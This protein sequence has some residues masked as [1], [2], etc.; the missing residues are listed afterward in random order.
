MKT[1]KMFIEFAKQ[2]KGK[3]SSDGSH[4]IIIDTYNSF[5]P[6]PRGYKV[7]YTDA[8]CATFI[9]A[10]SI[11]LGFT[12]IIPPE[13]SCEKMIEKFKAL[14][15]FIENEN[16]NVSV[17]DIV[18]YDWGDGANY[19]N[20]DNKSWCDHV[21]V[22]V[23][24]S[25]ETFTV[26]EGNYNGEVK[27]RTMK[28]NGKYLRG[29]AVPKYDK[30]ASQPVS[31]PSEKPSETVATSELKVGDV[32]TYK[33]TTHYTS[34][35]ATIAKN[36][37]GG[38]ATVTKIYPTGKHSIHLVRVYGKGATVYGWVD[39]K[40]IVK[41]QRMTKEEIQIYVYNFFYNKGL[42]HKSICAIMG[43]IT[44]ESAWNV[45]AIEQGNAIGFGLCQWSFERRTQLENYGVSLNHQCEFLYSELT[46]ENTNT[47]GA[48]YQWIANPADSVDNGEGFYCSN[49]DF[50]NGNG[51]IE[52]LTK[53]FCYCWERPA[54]ATNHLTETR[55]PSAITFSE[56]MGDDTGGSGDSDVDVLSP[57]KRKFKF[58]LFRKTRRF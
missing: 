5:K 27:E 25:R 30:E 13:C 8:W 17:G 41:G 11:R 57:V 39:A 43:N 28:V 16:R 47:T 55:I 9:S 35:N 3:K 50:R 31:K 44:A 45:E 54:Y 40:D 32:V 34:A 12:N 23:N 24:V 21:G 6:L 10:I 26:L 58:V 15:V 46:G 53:A 37:K 7:K 33:G 52:F 56:T 4:K 51:S 18:F 19:V 29:F 48:S 22:V 49:E 20:T 38:L 36:C 42:P 2:W 14:G 1:A